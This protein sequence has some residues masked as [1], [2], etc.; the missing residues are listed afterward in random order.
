M[1][2][3]GF[4]LGPVSLCCH[5]NKYRADE[6]RLASISLVSTLLYKCQGKGFRLAQD[7]NTIT[8]TTLAKYASRHH[9]FWATKNRIQLNGFQHNCEI[10]WSG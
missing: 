10:I 6:Y 9:Q 1:P 5:F 8:K 2:L 4:I 3:A 7:P